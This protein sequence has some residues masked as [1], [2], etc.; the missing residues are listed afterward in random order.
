M[1]SLVPFIMPLEPF[2]WLFCA[3]PTCRRVL[4][5]STLEYSGALSSHHSSAVEKRV[6]PSS[7]LH[8]IPRFFIITLTIPSHHYFEALNALFV[9]ISSIQALNL[10]N[11]IGDSWYPLLYLVL[12]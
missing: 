7:V 3:Y 12:R 10:L 1:P 9:L 6:N 2:A 8:S 11:M 4:T 5:F